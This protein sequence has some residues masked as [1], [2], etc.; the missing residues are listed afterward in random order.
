MP[1]RCSSPATTTT[2][3]R[4]TRSA[5]TPSR[6]PRTRGRTGRS[7]PSFSICSDTDRSALSRR[8]TGGRRDVV[9]VAGGVLDDHWEIVRQQVS[10]SDQLERRLGYLADV[11][12]LVVIAL[13]DRRARIAFLL[14]LHAGARQRNVR[15]LHAREHVG[16]S[17]AVVEQIPAGVG[18]E[19]NREL[20]H[21]DSG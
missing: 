11:L 2:S 5:P 10:L 7:S 9:P 3:S 18:R 21:S 17:R 16:G 12:V 1:G 6:R 19:R 8:R 15:A 20:R 13:F 4:A 14:S